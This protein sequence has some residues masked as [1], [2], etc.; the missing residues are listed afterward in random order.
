[1]EGEKKQIIPIRVRKKAIVSDYCN[2]QPES[3]QV[4]ALTVL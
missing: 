2:L 3:E 1:M 4:D